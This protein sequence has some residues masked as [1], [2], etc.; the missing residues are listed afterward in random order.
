[1]HMYNGDPEEEKEKSIVTEFEK[2]NILK[3]NGL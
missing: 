3:V 1:M 2:Q